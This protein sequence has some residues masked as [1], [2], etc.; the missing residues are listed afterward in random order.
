MGSKLEDIETVKQAYKPGP[1]THSPEKRNDIPSMKFGSG[2]RTS[3]ERKSFAPGP[4]NYEQDYSKNQKAAPK[5]GFGTSTRKEISKK[6]AP[7][8][9]TYSEKMYM[10]NDTAKYSM[11][12]VST[13]APEKK[14]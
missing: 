8:P 13:Y 10:G 11:G 3:M 12:A 5:F 14:E 7:A 1:G 9:G 4:G 6:W 2:Q